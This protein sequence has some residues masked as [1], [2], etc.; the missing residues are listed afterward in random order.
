MA[1]KSGTSWADTGGR[2]SSAGISG[3]AAGG[4]RIMVAK[5]QRSAQPRQQR[6]DSGTGAPSLAR[7]HAAV[8]AMQTALPPGGRAEHNRRLGAPPGPPRLVCARPFVARCERTWLPMTSG[9]PRPSVAAP[10]RAR[11]LDWLFIG[12]FLV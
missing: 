6:G 11:K 2:L 1:D 3:S 10:L 4:E 7:G 9:T 8:T 5:L 12:F